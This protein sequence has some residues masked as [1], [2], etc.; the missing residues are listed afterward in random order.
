MPTSVRKR[1]NTSATECK[2]PLIH[3][4]ACV[5][6]ETT[7][8]ISI[9]FCLNLVDNF[10]Y[11]FLLVHYNFS[12]TRDYQNHPASWLPASAND[13]LRVLLE[14]EG[15]S[16]VFLRSAVLSPRYTMLQLRKPFSSFVDISFQVST[17]R[18]K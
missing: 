12:F 15:G 14:S 13:L 5:I 1:Y 18:I 2:I 8:R 11:F 4:S 9:T 17:C 16:C 6:S 10:I 7:E 3:P